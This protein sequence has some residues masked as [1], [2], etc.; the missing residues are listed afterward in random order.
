MRSAPRS[1]YVPHF[2]T[3]RI[4]AS[5]AENGIGYVFLGKELGGRP[6]GDEFYDEEDHVLYS[7]LCESPLF[8]AGLNR[9]LGGANE[10]RVTM[11]CSE[12]DPRHC[13]R[14]LLIGRILQ[15]RH[16]AVAHIRGDGTIQTEDDLSSHQV[17]ATQG[18]LFEELAEERAW[19][20]T[21][22]VLRRKVQLTSSEF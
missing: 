2:D 22:S 11:L 9:M 19:R 7:R 5:L 1:R 13:H 8:E 14:H 20:S 6:V 4:R 10:F 21:R 3:K 12:E 18:A 16:V 17:K 15:E